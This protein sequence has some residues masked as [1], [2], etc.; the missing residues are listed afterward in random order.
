MS[1]RC[2]TRF[3]AVTGDR[4]ERAGREA[5]FHHEFGDADNAQTR[6]FRWIED[7]C[8]AHCHSRSNRPPL[9][10]HRIVQE[11]DV[12]R[13]TVGDAA[14]TIVEPVGWSSSLNLRTRGTS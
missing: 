8:V 14:H 5:R 4:I 7:C 1:H 10:L 6:I 13:H 2:R 11:D 12:R 3:V 9:H